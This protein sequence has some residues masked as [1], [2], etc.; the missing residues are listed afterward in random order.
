MA[1]TLD[2][3]SKANMVHSDLKPENILVNIDEKT[4]KFSEVKF[5]LHKG[6]SPGFFLFF[7]GKSN[8][9]WKLFPIK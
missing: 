5:F 4:K 2:V 3:F 6:P 7:V 9:F 8:R 1:H